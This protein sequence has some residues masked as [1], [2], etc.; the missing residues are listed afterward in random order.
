MTATTGSTGC[1]VQTALVKYIERLPRAQQ[2]A[3][4][5][6]LRERAKRRNDERSEKANRRRVVHEMDKM[7]REIQTMLLNGTVSATKLTQLK[8]QLKKLGGCIETR[9]P[10]QT[11][12]KAPSPV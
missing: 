8:G 12:Q 6:A 7:K 1:T 10:E 5:R 2:R 3:V 9:N 11:M 4:A